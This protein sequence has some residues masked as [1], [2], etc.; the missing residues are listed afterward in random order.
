MTRVLS[1]AKVGQSEFHVRLPIG[2]LPLHAG[3]SPNDLNHCPRTDSVISNLFPDR[4]SNDRL[5][6]S[7]TMRSKGKHAD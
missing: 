5:L 1:I 3:G 7:G 2:L 4:P 6:K